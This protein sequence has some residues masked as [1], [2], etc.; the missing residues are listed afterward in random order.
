MSAGLIAHRRAIETFLK[1][2]KFESP[3]SALGLTTK[4]QVQPSRKL[5]L[6]QGRHEIAKRV[7]EIVPV[8]GQSL[9]I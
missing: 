5:D 7:S 1:S 4:L 3:E 8:G 6:W 9:S 2:G